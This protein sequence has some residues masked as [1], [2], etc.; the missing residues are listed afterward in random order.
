MSECS[1]SYACNVSMIITTCRLITAFVVVVV[2]AAKRNVGRGFRFC[3]QMFASF[4]VHCWKIVCWMR[5]WKQCRK[6]FRINLRRFFFFFFVCIQ[7]QKMSHRSAEQ[8]EQNQIAT[9]SKKFFGLQQKLCKYL[10]IYLSIHIH[11][12]IS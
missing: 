10:S 8:T 7:R 9:A 1:K 3:D 12:C 4:C 5:Q 6:S 11:T 2:V